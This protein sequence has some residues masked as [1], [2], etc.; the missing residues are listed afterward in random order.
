[1]TEPGKE[2]QPATGTSIEMTLKHGGD[3]TMQTSR[4]FF[5]ALLA[6]AALVIMS[7]SAFGADPGIPYPAA[8]EVSDQKAGS[9]LVYNVYTSSTA[10]PAAQNTIMSITNTSATS[11]A[12]VHLFFV[13]NNCS[14]ADR[15]IC[16][17]ALQTATIDAFSEDP[18][19]TG[20]LIAVAGDGVTGCPTSF[21]YLIGSEFAKFS[22]GYFGA[23]GAEAFSALYEG[24]LPGC[25]ANSVD[26][27]LRFNGVQGIGYNRVPRVLAAS[28]LGSRADQ[29]FHRIFVNSMNGNLFTSVDSFGNL[30]G[31]VYDEAEA[32]YSWTLPGNCQLTG[33]L[34]DANFPRTTPRFEVIIPQ[35]S[36]GWMKFWAISNTTN[37]IIGAIFTRNPTAGQNQNAFNGARNLHK[38]TLAPT[39]T[40]TMPIF[41]PSC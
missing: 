30:F 24:T 10:N 15:F 36:T 40:L 35:N 7:A 23:L 18:G 19:I 22:E 41:P 39:S 4:K 26:A 12:F 11:A 13:A 2:K 25:D 9:V 31:I 27:V 21:N 34:G 6:A 8:S 17:T 5:N 16:L 29:T 37:G 1:M 32:T 14:V 20:F 33:V 28:S 38:L 3:S